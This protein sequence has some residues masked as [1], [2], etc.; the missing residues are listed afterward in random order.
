MTRPTRD[1][2]AGRVYL[3]LRRQARAEG[4]G[5]DEL[6]VLYVLE[7]FLYRLSISRH[8]E[9]L[10]L[11]GGMLLAAFD[12][13]RPTR[14][15]DLLGLAI[16]NDAASV[17]A[18]VVEIVRLEVDDGVVFHADQVTSRLIREQDVY[19]AV[20]VAM[21]ATVATAELALKVDVNVGDPVTPAPVEITYPALLDEPFR[22]VGYPLETVLA[23]KLVTMIARGDTT[24][25]D[26]DFADVWLLTGRH[27]LEAGSLRE[28]IVATAGYRDVIV[29]P[30]DDVLSTL[31]TDRQDGWRRYL[32]RTGLA[33]V[34]PGILEE[35]IADIT[36]FADPILSDVLDARA[37]WDPSRRRWST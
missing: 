5:T 36:A 31:A 22:M 12:E 13:R 17:I 29:I 27:Q 7:R 3:N 15:V 10:I 9:R 18:L 21:P 8:R 6:L 23:E 1:T 2:T 19:A 30:I 14:D 33:D 32:T 28:A 20:R 35:V 26:R 24:T 16:D 11:K 37:D 4:R 34:V 25:R